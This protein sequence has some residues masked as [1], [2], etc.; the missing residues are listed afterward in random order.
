MK[1][2]FWLITLCSIASASVAPFPG[3]TYQATVSYTA[4]KVL[5]NGS[6]IAHIDL[7]ELSATWWS[8]CNTATNIVVTDTGNADTTTHL[9]WID[10]F[11]KPTKVGILFFKVSLSTASGG[12]VKVQTGT[13]INVANNKAV[14]TDNNIYLRYGMWLVAEHPK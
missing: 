1:R 10:G 7:S 8:N 12:V 2:I 6:Y 13:T 14:F 9:K 11:D 5:E 4:A 3:A